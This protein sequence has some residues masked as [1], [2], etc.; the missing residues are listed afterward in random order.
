MEGIDSEYPGIQPHPH[1]AAL[2][3]LRL[4]TADPSLA[5]K[6]WLAVFE[7]CRWKSAQC[8]TG[9][10]PTL[11]AAGNQHHATSRGRGSASQHNTLQ[12]LFC[13]AGGRRM[14]GAG[15]GIDRAAFIEVLQS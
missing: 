15:E 3:I 4:C 2:Y 6:M 11:P 13:F 14:G 8:S 5:W 7:Q 10:Y 9:L 12:H 1:P